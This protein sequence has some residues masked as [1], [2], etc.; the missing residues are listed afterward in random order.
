MFIIDC[1]IMVIV[2]A[3]FATNPLTAWLIPGSLVYDG[4][5]IGIRVWFLCCLK[6]WVDDLEFGDGGKA[7][8]AASPA[9]AAAPIN[10]VVQN[11]NTNTNAGA[12]PMQPPMMQQPMMQQPMMQQPMQQPMMQQPMQQPMMQQPQWSFNATVTNGNTTWTGDCDSISTMWTTNPIFCV[13]VM[14]K[15]RGWMNPS[16]FKSRKMSVETRW[17]K[18]PLFKLL[19]QWEANK[20]CR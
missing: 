15:E 3:L 2:L 12:P 18:I 8:A 11:T 6:A 13:I 14:T 19:F 17:S 4:I 7:P 5:T 10:I 16:S 9:P 1:V 20:I